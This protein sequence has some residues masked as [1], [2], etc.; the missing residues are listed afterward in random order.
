VITSEELTPLLSA[1]APKQRW[2]GG[3]GRE[4]AMSVD[5]LA[6]LP[7]GSPVT[8]WTLTAHYDDGTTDLYQLPLVA[9]DEP[10][11]TLEHVLVGTVDTDTGT[12]WVYDALHDKDVTCGTR[13]AMAR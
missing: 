13:R 10:V 1:W 3:K 2:F 7:D 11:N 8:I 4:A 9:H 6:E 12:K 5:R